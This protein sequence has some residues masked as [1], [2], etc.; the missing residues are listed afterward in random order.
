[1]GADRLAD[2]LH[3]VVRRFQ[4][5][6]H[7]AEQRGDEEKGRAAHTEPTAT[8]SPVLRPSATSHAVVAA[9]SLR[10]IGIPGPPLDAPGPGAGAR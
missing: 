3:I 10:L 9:P 4:G 1:M 7:D 2:T 8:A 6:E 5:H